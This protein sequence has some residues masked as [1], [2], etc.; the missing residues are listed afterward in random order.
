ML[1]PTDQ[2]DYLFLSSAEFEL[3]TTTAL[4]RYC[5]CTIL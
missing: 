2:I 4:R 3:A 1:L 5:L